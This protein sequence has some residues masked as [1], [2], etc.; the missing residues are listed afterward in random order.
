MNYLILK[1]SHLTFVVIS[2]CL[3]STRFLCY[4]C[5]QCP[6]PR[7]LKIVPHAIDSLLLVSALMMA[8]L[9]GFT[10]ANSPWLLAKIIALLFYIGL[11]SIA[12]KARGVKQWLAF[13]AACLCFAYIVM[14][15]LTKHVWVVV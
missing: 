10:P 7:W 12:M 14:V 11:G 9:V 2:F 1:H 15:A 5:R 3:F 6:L 8:W 4:A 13:M